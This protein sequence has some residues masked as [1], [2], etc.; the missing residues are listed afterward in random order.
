[1]RSGNNGADRQDYLQASHRRKENPLPT[2]V[3]YKH[4][5]GSQLCHH[6]LSPQKP[7]AGLTMTW[8]SMQYAYLDRK[9]PQ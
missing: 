1:M 7:F 4:D 9:I 8:G 5:T 6:I 2:T 3:Y